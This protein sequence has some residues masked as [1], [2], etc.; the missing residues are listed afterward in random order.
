MKDMQK[1][2]R[3]AV[4][5]LIQVCI[6]GVSYGLITKQAGLSL[7]ESLA[8]SLLVFAGSAQFAAVGMLDFALLQA[9]PILFTTLLINLRLMLYSA[10]LAPDMKSFP[11][12]RQALLAFCVTDESYALTAAHFSLHGVN[13]RYQLGAGA[14]IYIAWGV[15]SGV[16]AALGGFIHDPLS[17]GLDFV[18]P[19]CFITLVIPLLR[20]WK[21]LLVFLTAGVLSVLGMQL[22]PGKW[23]IIAATL[24][25]VLL[26]GG[27][28]RLCESKSSS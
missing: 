2:V 25:A 7:M 23:Y 24:L 12:G 4:P 11:L 28:E 10:S 13:Y 19:A 9:G 21:E 22:L 18:L 5:V 6:T 1:A 14:S 26:G 3:D 17:W 8:M 16:G 15:A 20:A 27:V